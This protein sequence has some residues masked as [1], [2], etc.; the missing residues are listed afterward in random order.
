MGSIMGSRLSHLTHLSSR[1]SIR[2]LFE[3]LFNILSGFR[4]NFSELGL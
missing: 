4:T 1:K 2:N 3:Q